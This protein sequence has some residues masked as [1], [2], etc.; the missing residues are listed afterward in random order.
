M[1]S[2]TEKLAVMENLPEPEK[3]EEAE[4]VAELAIFTELENLTEIG[5][6]IDV[7]KPFEGTKSLDTENRG[8]QRLIHTEHSNRVGS[9]APLPTSKVTD[10]GNLANASSC[11]CQK[12]FARPRK[13]DP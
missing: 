1:L 13:I 10:P 12:Q 4:N 2:D 6:S 5:N 3:L 9:H 8:L 11:V 7:D